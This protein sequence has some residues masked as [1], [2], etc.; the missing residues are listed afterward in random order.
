MIGKLHY[1]SEDTG[2]EEALKI[3]SMTWHRDFI[4]RKQNFLSRIVSV[5]NLGGEY[6]NAYTQHQYQVGATYIMYLLYHK[7]IIL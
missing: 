3:I 1:G 7:Q 2:F 4:N 6:P 5:S